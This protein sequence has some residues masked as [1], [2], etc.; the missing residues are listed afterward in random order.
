M[1][2]IESKVLRILR[3]NHKDRRAFIEKTVQSINDFFGGAR[4]HLWM[5]RDGEVVDTGEV[6]ILQDML[7]EKYDEY[8]EGNLQTRTG[9][10]GDGRTMFRLY[11]DS[12]GNVAAGCV[13]ESLTKREISESVTERLDNI[14]RT[15]VEHAMNWN[16]TKSEE[17]VKTDTMC[18]AEFYEML[19]GRKFHMVACVAP[20]T[21]IEIIERVGYEELNRMLDGWTDTARQFGSIAAVRDGD[22]VLIGSSRFGYA[23]CELIN[24][25][26]DAIAEAGKEYADE[27]L[28][29]ATIVFHSCIDG[30]PLTINDLCA[31]REAVPKR[32]GYGVTSLEVRLPDKQSEITTERKEEAVKEEKSPAA[33][34]KISELPKR[35]TQKKKKEEPEQPPALFI[36]AGQLGERNAPE[37]EDKEEPLSEY[38]DDEPE[39]EEKVKKSGN[40]LIEGFFTDD[41]LIGI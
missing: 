3:G 18:I 35:K 17:P 6:S 12:T 8:V 14:L 21:R 1:E 39:N 29:G 36:E 13:I 10:F 33:E 41:H 11:K 25:L 37:V 40:D 9:C 22:M 23:A 38:M 28:R 20:D 34:I 16:S 31:V 15:V 2:E 30:S 7:L 26:C 5:I 19:K 4:T 27:G 32:R 24:E